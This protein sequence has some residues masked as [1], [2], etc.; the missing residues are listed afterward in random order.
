MGARTPASSAFIVS[1]MGDAGEMAELTADDTA[2]CGCRGAW[3]LRWWTNLV[4]WD[5]LVMRHEPRCQ[6]RS[7]HGRNPGNAEGGNQ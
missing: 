2:A 6:T 4:R 7:G 3:Y 5:L 1:V